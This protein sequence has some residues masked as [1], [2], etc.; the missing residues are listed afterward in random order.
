MFATERA[1]NE[2]LSAV[3]EL[4]DTAAGVC[5]D[6]GLHGHAERAFRFGAGCA[7]ESG[8]WSMRAKALSG[9]AN[10]SVHR[11]R[12]TKRSASPNS[13]RCAQTA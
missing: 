9:L 11:G 12:R 7:T 4:A 6:S 2:L 8:D 1:R 13:R 5:F 10:L 3:A